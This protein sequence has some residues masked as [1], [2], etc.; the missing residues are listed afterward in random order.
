MPGSPSPLDL[1]NLPQL[2]GRL[3]MSGATLETLQRVRTLSQDA[4]ILRQHMTA[5]VVEMGIRTQEE[6]ES[7]GIVA[8]LGLIF[9]RWLSG[10]RR[11]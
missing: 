5:A 9:D 11:S 6:A 1:E 10:A 7:L 3:M 4:R 8:M 2:L